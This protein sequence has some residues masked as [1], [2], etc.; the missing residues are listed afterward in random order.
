MQIFG[1]VVGNAVKF[2]PKGGSIT[3]SA[4]APASRFSSRCATPG[5]ASLLPMLE[6]LFERYWQ[7]EEGAQKGR[8]LGLYIAKQLVEAQGGR[9]W[10]ESRPGAGTTIFFT[11]PRS[12]PFQAVVE[13]PERSIGPAPARSQSLSRSRRISPVALV[14]RT[15]TVSLRSESQA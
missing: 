14:G 6:H 10:A 13:S 9:I 1:N 2:T 5:R 4:S 3:V 15:T 8:G 11:L 12:N 7:A